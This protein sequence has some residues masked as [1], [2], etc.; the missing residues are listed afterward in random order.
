MGSSDSNC[1]NKQGLCNIN[2][3]A[4]RFSNNKNNVLLRSIYTLNPSAYKHIR[5]IQTAS[6]LVTLLN[7][8]FLVLTCNAYEDVINDVNKYAHKYDIIIVW[9]HGEI[10]DMLRHIAFVFNLDQPSNFSWPDDN[11]NGCLLVDTQK[12]TWAF[13]PNYFNNIFFLNYFFRKIPCIG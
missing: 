8:N 10:P 7:D 9:H 6:T 11:Y 2:K 5:P 3:I 1:L 12:H 13:R 4:T